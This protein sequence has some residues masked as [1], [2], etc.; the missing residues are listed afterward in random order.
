MTPYSVGP[1][2]SSAA[3]TLGVPHHEADRHG[4]FRRDAHHVVRCHGY[5]DSHTVVVA[6]LRLVERSGALFCCASATVAAGEVCDVLPDPGGG[7]HGVHGAVLV[8]GNPLLGS[9][10]GLGAVHAQH[11]REGCLVKPDSGIW[12]LRCVAMFGTSWP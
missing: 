9:R 2:D 4:T 5:G 6:V 12:V 3:T 10:G 7:G 8:Q 11:C 1:W